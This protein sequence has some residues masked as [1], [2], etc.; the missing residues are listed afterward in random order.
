MQYAADCDIPGVLEVN[1]PLIEEQSEHRGLINAPLARD[2][3]AQC[4]AN[5]TLVAAV[6]EE[7]C[8]YVRRFPGANVQVRSRGPVSF[9]PFDG[10]ML[11]ESYAGHTQTIK[12]TILAAMR[13]DYAGYDVTILSSDE[14]A[15]PSAPH[16][17]R[18]W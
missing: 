1:A 16:S 8:G 10:A 9:E 7:V 4:V 13:A 17:G 3:I 18:R 15:E 6:S 11:G 2:V 5:A 14:V 12:D